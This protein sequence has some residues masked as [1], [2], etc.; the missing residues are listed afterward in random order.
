MGVTQAT[1]SLPIGTVRLVK[2]LYP[3]LKKDDAA[4][5]RYRAALDRLPPITIARD[6][7]L[8]DGFHRWQAHLAE[9]STEIQAEHLGDLT[10]SEIIRESIRRNAAHGQQLSAAD[11]RRL[12]GKLWPTLDRKT[13]VAELAELLSVSDRAVQDWTKDARAQEKKEQQAKAWDLW[14]NCHTQQ[15]IAEQL[16]IPQQTIADWLTE[17]RKDAES[18]KAPESQQHF[19]IWQFGS[20]GGSSNHFGKMP[21]QIVENLL[22]LWTRPGDIVVD[23]FAGGGTTIDVAKQM[24]RRIWASDLHPTNPLLPIHT[25]DITTGW[26]DDAPSKVDLIL[27]D[28]PYWKQAAGQYSDSPDDLGNMSYEGFIAAWGRI[29]KACVSHITDYGRLAYIVSPA[30]DGP[31]KDGNVEDLATAMLPACWANALRVERRIIVP[32]STQQAT[33]QQVDAAREHRRLL[34]LYRDLVVLL[35]FGV[36]P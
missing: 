28:P 11:K 21:P 4:I 35:D 2:E 19:D 27:L 13:R 15:E 36:R 14:L 22:W 10:D 29:V 9:G 24:G 33:G 32:Y 5:E 25:H 31:L 16:G 1:S 3:R 17:K 12:A 18:G 26:P 7:V 34:K 6:G 8:V 20:D 30:Q 23:P